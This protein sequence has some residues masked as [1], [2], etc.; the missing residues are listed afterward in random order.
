[1]Y[2]KRKSK[3]A[4]ETITLIRQMAQ[5]NR[6]WGAVRIRGELLKLGI[7]V[8]KR[9]V[10]KYLRG[11]R[12]HQPRGQKWSTDLAQSR[13][14]DLGLRRAYRSPLSSF[15]RSQAFFL[16]EL[17]SRKVIHV[18]ATRSPTDAWAAR[19]APGSDAVWASTQVSD[20]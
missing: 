19:T 15:D 12:S 4:E 9:A 6:L 13:R 10:Q 14:T 2:W 16:V 18:G 8:C 1:L 17:Q 5:E 11:V 20:L 7:R 3:V